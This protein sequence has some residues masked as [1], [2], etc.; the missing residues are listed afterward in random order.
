M[1]LQSEKF[2]YRKLGTSMSFEFSDC[3]SK[4]T[5][6]TVEFVFIILNKIILYNEKSDFF[7]LKLKKNK[8]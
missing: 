8:T 7:F 4:R 2:Y 5:T 1:R 3:I 6:F